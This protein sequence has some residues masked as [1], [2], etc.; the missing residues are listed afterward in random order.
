MILL[1]TTHA[2][3][4][5]W[6]I[7]YYESCVMHHVSVLV[8]WIWW[9]SCCVEGNDKVQR[10]AWYH[11]QG[12]PKSLK[13]KG[14]FCTVHI[15]FHEVW[16]HF[17]DRNKNCIWNEVFNWERSVS[18]VSCFSLLSTPTPSTR[19]TLHKNH[20][21]VA[22]R[23]ITLMLLWNLAI[24]IPFALIWVLETIKCYFHIVASSTLKKIKKNEKCHKCSKKILR[25][26]CFC[27]WCYI[28]KFI[29]IGLCG[30]YILT[31][32]LEKE[33]YYVKNKMSYA[34]FNFYNIKVKSL[35][36]NKCDK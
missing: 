4:Q 17:Q 24:P 3:E 31:N 10:K 1:I 15:T 16:D 18:T 20:T 28:E 22:W 34:V 9:M 23:L 26:L 33:T 7:N 8:S 35:I 27:Y 12:S 32:L 13:N 11:F 21:L 29:I 14:A 6:R 30:L 19:V 2:L 5:G 36:K 25:M